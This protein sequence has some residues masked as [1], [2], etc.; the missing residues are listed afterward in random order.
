VVERGRAARVPAIYCDMQASGRGL[1]AGMKNG[2]SGRPCPV[3]PAVLFRLTTAEDRLST[4]REK[5]S[6]FDDA[7]DSW[8]MSE[9]GGALSTAVLT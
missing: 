4:G 2:G 1:G 9:V 3:L 7:C 5:V 6:V 8:M